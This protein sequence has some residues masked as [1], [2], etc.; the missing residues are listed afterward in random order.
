[1]VAEHGL[2]LLVDQELLKVP[3][4]VTVLEGLVVQA[5]A[6]RVEDLLDWRAVGLKV[7]VHWVFFV[8]VDID[9]LKKWKNWLETPSR[10]HVFERV[11]DFRSIG[12]RLLLSKLVARE[13]ENV[14]VFEVLLQCIQSVVLVSGPSESSHVH[15]Q[16]HLVVVAGE[17]DQALLVDVHE[18]EVVQ[19][20]LAVVF[21]ETQGLAIRLCWSQPDGQDQ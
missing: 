10:P 19:R 18:T 20:R 11:E 15:N 21:L 13:A 16:Q 14:E 3:P 1:M 9:L 8:S 17:V 6:C 5:R 4:H 7:R 2:A 12:S